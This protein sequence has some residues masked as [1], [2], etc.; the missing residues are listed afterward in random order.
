MADLAKAL[1]QGYVYDGRHAVHRRRRHG[2]PPVGLS[3]HRFLGYAQTHDQV[4]NR[5]RGER[6]CQLVN[7]ARAKL[8]AALVLTSP[9]VP[10]LF[11]GEEGGASTPFQYF[12][13]HE[14]PDLAKAIRE[15][16]RREFA[17]FGWKPEDV[18]DPQA[19]ETFERSKLNWAELGTAPHA[20]MLNWHRQ[21]MQLR[22]CEP[23]L[24]D[25]CLDL[26]Q[27]QFDESAGWFVLERG[28]LTVALSF[29]GNSQPVP[30]RPGRQ[31][32]LLS[33]SAKTLLSDCAVSLPSDAVAILRWQA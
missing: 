14:E 23:A 19:S 25:G 33:S 4:G 16:R 3:G 13:D 12:A 26:V 20:E 9:F 6:L 32:L 31:Q 15:G 1:R 24:T 22:Q 2:R 5:A 30:I 21:L 27:T 18:P 7:P 29:A 8:A 28:V 10:M 17:A 11:Q